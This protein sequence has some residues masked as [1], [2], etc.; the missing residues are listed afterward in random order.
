MTGRTCSRIKAVLGVSEVLKGADE[1][2][3]LKLASYL[4]SARDA[5]KI[6]TRALRSVLRASQSQVVIFLLL[7]RTHAQ[8][9]SLR[10]L[11]SNIKLTSLEP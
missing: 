4:M 7:N 11:I 5:P 1:E 9:G 6:T 8:N 10:H 3:E 2:T